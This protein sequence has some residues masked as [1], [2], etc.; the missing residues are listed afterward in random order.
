V[1]AAVVAALTDD[2]PV[3][4]AVGVAPNDH[5]VTL[6]ARHKGETGNDIDVRANYRDGESTPAGIGAA[7]VAMSGG[8]T[9]PVLTT[10]ITAMGDQWYNVIAFP[11]TDA[12]S[13]TAIEGELADRFGPTRMVDGVAFACKAGNHATATALADGRNSP[14]VSIMGANSSPTPTYE[15]A[16]NVAAVVAYYGVSDP[17]RP[18]QTLPLTWVLAPAES[19]RWTIVQRNLALYDNL[20]TFKVAAGDVVQ[21]ERL[22]TTYETNSAGAPDT[23]YYDVTTM[24]TLMY[25][26]YSFRTDFATKYPRHKLAA[27]G[28]RINAGQAIITPLLGKA[29]ALH[30]FREM[31]GLGLVE[32]FDQFKRDLVVER[33][34]TDTNRL[35][36]LLPPDV[37]NQLVVTAAKFE[38]RL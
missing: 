31:E 24:L 34:A 25:L 21:I 33:N 12:T 11:Y 38:F 23:A 26:R 4:G 8:T 6:T 7:I 36:F 16:A 1:A 5:V 10:L 22:V 35:D 9:N 30:W 15:I 13:L 18:F 19:A 3:T 17:A 28:T 14:H 2:L 27:D 29:E 32:G 37:M 20:S